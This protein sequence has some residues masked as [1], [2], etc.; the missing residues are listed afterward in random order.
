MPVGDE[1][2]VGNGGSGHERSRVRKVPSRVVRL[3]LLALH[4]SGSGPFDKLRA[5]MWRGC[6]HATRR[7]GRGVSTGT[8]AALPPIDG[9]AEAR[10]WNNRDGL[11]KKSNVIKEADLDA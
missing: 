9:L 2:V 5:R 3:I 7:A 1:G 10:P 11:W 4:G 6:P 8:S